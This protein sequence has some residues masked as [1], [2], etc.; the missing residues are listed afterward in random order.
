MKKII[1]L[2]LLVAGAISFATAQSRDQKDF[3]FNKDKKTNSHFD[4]QPSHS[5]STFN[6]SYYFSLREK[7]AKLQKINAAFYQKIAAVKSNRY[8]NGREKARQIQKLEDQKKFEIF[9][10]EQQFAKSNHSAKD[11]HYGHDAKKW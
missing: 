7:E 4:Q 11:D 5:N 9:Q 6:D 3:A 10:V 8:L 1:T 2:I